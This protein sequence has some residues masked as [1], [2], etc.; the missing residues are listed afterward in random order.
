MACCWESTY[1]E[2][3]II[4]SVIKFIKILKFYKIV[5]VSLFLLTRGNEI[6]EED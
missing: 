1:Q 3:M 2:F 4:W 5:Q 6:P